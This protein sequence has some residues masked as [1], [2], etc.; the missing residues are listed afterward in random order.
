MP[1]EQHRPVRRIIKP[2]LYQ[3][4][5]KDEYDDLESVEY[6]PYPLGARGAFFPTRYNSCANTLELG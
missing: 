3:Q 6:I 5:R 1:V 2:T 4:G